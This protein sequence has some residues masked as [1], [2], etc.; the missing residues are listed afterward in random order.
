MFRLAEHASSRL[1]TLAL[2][3]AGLACTAL[4]VQKLVDG[5]SPATAAPSRGAAPA[6][7][8]IEAVRVGDVVLAD[9]RAEGD[10]SLGLAPGGGPDPAAWRRV[11]LRV[12]RPGGADADVEL[13]RPVAWLEERGVAEGGTLAMYSEE[14]GIDGDGRVLAVEPCPPVGPVPPGGAV[15][16]GTYRYAGGEPLDLLVEGQAEPL[17]VTAQHK[18][19]SETREDFVP[20]GELAVGEE[21]LTTA[22]RAAVRSVSPRGPP[23]PVFNLEVG[24]RHVFRVGT[25]G[26]L[27]HNTS[28]GGTLDVGGE[29]RYPGAVNLNPYE[30]GMTGE[31]IPGRVPGRSDKFPFSND[32]FDTVI[33]E[34]APIAPTT[35]GEV[36]RVLKPRGTVRLSSPDDLVID[37]YHDGIVNEFP[38]GT[39]SI[40]W[41]D[42]NYVTEIFTP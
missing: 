39:T 37:G 31:V 36:V 15:V 7:S 30:T 3:I 18:V 9:A 4:G 6:S 1:L 23:E 14:V 13:L 38:E 21:V 5:R 35:P 8:P 17:G 34:N 24:L 22:G 12:P 42:G 20:A 40:Y 25:A 10:R 29:G 19:W 27:V 16:T 33:I 32:S 28:G 2:L 41:D 11:R 26:V